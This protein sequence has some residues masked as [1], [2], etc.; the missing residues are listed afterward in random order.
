MAI[1]V[2]GGVLCMPDGATHWD[3]LDKNP[4]FK[5]VLT[6]VG[7][8]TAMTDN[9]CCYRLIGV[10]Y[11]KDERY[12]FVDGVWQLC[13]P[14]SFIAGDALFYPHHMC[15]REVSRLEYYSGVPRINTVF[16][17]G[18][19]LGREK[20]NASRYIIDLDENPFSF[21][22]VCLFGKEVLKANVV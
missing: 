12:Q 10:G 20:N 5:I 1:Q 22:P 13:K 15:L 7:P 6:E 19:L 14:V 3:Q 17:Q 11:Y 8:D 16:G 21:S 2:E 18:Y 4:F 9:S